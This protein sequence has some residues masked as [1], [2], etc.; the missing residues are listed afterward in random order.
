M[1]FVVCWQS[2]LAMADVW[3]CKRQH[4]A[5]ATLEK[6]W[7]GVCHDSFAS[8]QGMDAQT[9]AFSLVKAS[10]GCSLQCV[11]VQ[12]LMFSRFALVGMMKCPLGTPDPAPRALTLVPSLVEPPLCTGASQKLD[13]FLAPVPWSLCMPRLTRRTQGFLPSAVRGVHPRENSNSKLEV[14]LTH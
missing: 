14:E 7:V 13:F 3:F 9:E 10:C 2:G 6:S 5:L 4:G 12:V 8:T 1:W 11:S